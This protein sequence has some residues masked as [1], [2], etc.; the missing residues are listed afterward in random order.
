MHRKPGKFSL[1]SVWNKPLHQTSLVA[2]T[3]KRLSTTWKTWV[4]SLGQE[5]NGTP[6]QYSS[7]ENPMDR[8]AWC[9][10]G[11]KESDTT[12]QLYFLSL[13]PTSGPLHGPVSLAGASFSLGPAHSLPQ[14]PVV[15]T[16]PP[17]LES[18]SLKYPSSAC[19]ASLFVIVVTITWIN[20]AVY[21]LLP[22]SLTRT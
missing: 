15:L 14:D 6:F 18:P 13:S 12:E 4:R 17:L 1:H 10:W 20:S 5:G 8:G 11:R 3:V 7:L 19:L 21:L 2:Q 9:P 22:L 16:H